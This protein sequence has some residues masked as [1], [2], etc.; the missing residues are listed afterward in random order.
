MNKQ[1]IAVGIILVLLVVGFSGCTQKGTNVDTAEM[2]KFVGVWKASE[3]DIHIFSRDGTCKYLNVLGRYG[4]ENGQVTVN[5]DNGQKY[6]YYYHFSDNN[7]V[8]TLTHV[9]RGY[10]TIYTKQQ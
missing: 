1:L 7:T 3:Y 8:L 6:M 9:D 10:T 4:L 5:L 2:S